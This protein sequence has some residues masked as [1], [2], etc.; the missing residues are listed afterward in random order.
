MSKSHY[1][2]FLRRGKKKNVFIVGFTLEAGGL[3][4]LGSS[5]TC[6]EREKSCFTDFIKLSYKHLGLDPKCQDYAVHGDVAAAGL[7][8][9]EFGREKLPQKHFDSREANIFH[10]NERIG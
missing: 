1:I 8:G 10:G 2:I 9:T 7:T 6:P 5:F 3:E 4:E